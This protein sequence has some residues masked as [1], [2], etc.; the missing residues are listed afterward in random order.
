ANQMAQQILGLNR[1]EIGFVSPGWQN[2]RLDGSPLP[3]EEFPV[4]LTISS[5]MPMYDYEIGMIAP[6]QETVYI[7][8]N[9]APICDEDNTIISV[10]ATFMD[11][12]HRRKVIQQKDEFISVASHELRTPVTSLKASLQLLDRIKMEPDVVLMPTLIDQANKSLNKVSVLIDDLLNSTKL[13]EGQLHLKKKSFNLA[14]LVRD[15]SQQVLAAGTHQ[16]AVEGNLDTE[17]YADADKVDQVLVNL[18]N[19]AMKYAP[20]SRSI[21]A[22]IS[23]EDGFA[24]IS[25]TDKGP[26]IPA[27][28][29]PHLF[30]RYFRVDLN[31]LQYSGLGLGLYIC[32]Q[33]IKR[34]NGTIGV[35]SVVGEGSTFWFTLPL[36]SIE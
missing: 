3:T 32:A 2:V 24:R 35:E 10:I 18:F 36:V 26:G 4:P 30:D 11:V 20:E 8:V 28:K 23:R 1:N 5:G 29:L 15:V 14:Q 12:T 6:G 7:S 33:I 19:N 27:E 16:I 17:V 25:V 13:T 9:T 21:V 34:H 31:G 22:G